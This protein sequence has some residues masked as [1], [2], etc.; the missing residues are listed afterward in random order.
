MLA[1]DIIGHEVNLPWVS[2]AFPYAEQIVV[3]HRVLRALLWFGM[4]FGE[5]R[6]AFERFLRPGEKL[7]P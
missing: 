4:P 1:Q 6:Q 2:R 7:L 3:L 5:N